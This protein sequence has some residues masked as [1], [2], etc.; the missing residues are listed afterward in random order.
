MIK[1]AGENYWYSMTNCDIGINE[2]YLGYKDGY[3][4]RVVIAE[5]SKVVA[6][7][8]FKSEKTARTFATKLA[9]LMNGDD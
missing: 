1:K 5:D 9:H 3:L 4:Y 8:S 2:V 6:L 7:K